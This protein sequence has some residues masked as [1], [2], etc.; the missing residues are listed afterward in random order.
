MCSNRFIGSRCLPRCYHGIIA[1]RTR[2]WLLPLILFVVLCVALLT[3]WKG[4]LAFLGNLLV[5]GASPRSADLILVLGG[6]FWGP[7]VLKGADLAVAGYAPLALISGVPYQGRPEGEAAIDFLVARGYP[8][9]LFQSFEHFSRSTIGEAL[10]LRPELERR[11]V[12][13]VLL[14]TS[15]YHSRRAGI[16]F[17]LFCPGIQF[18]T[19]GAPDEHYRPDVWWEDAV[20]RR[21]FFSEWGK[22]FGTILIEYPKYRLQ[23][24]FGRHAV[25]PAEAGT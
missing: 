6:D 24:A 17:R 9:R 3:G 13:R 18:V 23:S 8:R 16:V 10:A 20:S 1:A 22:I 14:V 25:Q 15:A 7:R 4:V 2:R 5:S 11:G 21:L 19:I 12:H